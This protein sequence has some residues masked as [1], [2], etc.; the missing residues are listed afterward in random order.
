MDLWL[1]TA[2]LDGR[3]DI[4]DRRLAPSSVMSTTRKHCQPRQRLDFYPELGN[5][6]PAKERHHSPPNFGSCK[7]SSHLFEDGFCR[8]YL[9]N[10]LG[11]GTHW[12]LI[13]ATIVTHHVVNVPIAS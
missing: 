13:P 7:L 1:S 4:R 3:S 5:P 8:S 10:Q 12:L 2:N 11:L 9:R 6:W